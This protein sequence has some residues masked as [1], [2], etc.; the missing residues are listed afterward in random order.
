MTQTSV[1]GQGE[2]EAHCSSPGVGILITA[3]ATS[4]L[5]L[6]MSFT[7]R[8]SDYKVLRESVRQRR[9]GRAE[10][11]MMEGQISLLQNELPA[12]TKEPQNESV[13]KHQWR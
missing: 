10:N 4:S 8:T 5:G 9:G 1:S 11:K 13:H 7:C 12:V 3:A 6:D 2:C